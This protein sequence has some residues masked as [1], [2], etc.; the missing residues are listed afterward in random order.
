V[1][2]IEQG[3]RL[4]S[5]ADLMAEKE[6]AKIGPP[7]PRELRPH[8][9][10]VVTLEDGSTEDWLVL[11]WGGYDYSVE[12]KRIRT[13]MDLLELL[14]HVLQKGWRIDGDKIYRLINAVCN[15]KGWDMYE[16]QPSQNRAEWTAKQRGA[17]TPEL[18]W[19]TLAR[20]GFR[21]VACGRGA[22]DG[23]ALHVDHATPIYEGGGT[24][25]S[26][27]QTLCSDCNLGKKHKA[28]R[29]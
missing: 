20:N 27:L 19:K 7:C 14:H 2:T 22:S 1:G 16:K 3:F 24:T 18:R 4:Y 21:C 10:E 13:P 9:F 26:N 15:R 8:R 23:V 28:W 11:R 6:A 12:M 29:P 17:L 5:I 25:A